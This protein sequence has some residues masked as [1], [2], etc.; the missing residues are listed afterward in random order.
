M[1]AATEAPAPRVQRR[2][3]P[4]VRR[5]QIVV[6]AAR[7]VSAAGFNAVSLNDIAEA[8]EIRKSSVLHHFPSM[9]DL[10]AAVLAYRDEMAA[11][12]QPPLEELADPA[13]ASAFF[14]GTVEHNAQ[15]RELVRLYAVLRVE[16]I[17]PSHPAHAYFRNR[18]QST[19]DSFTAILAWKPAP[20][21]AAREIYAF[22]TGLETLWVAD[23]SVDMLAV[24][25]S[26][27]SRFFSVPSGPSA[28]A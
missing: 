5:R 13:A 22:W 11:P 26:F 28:C 16:A 15:H 21:L 17:D 7:L 9:V 24:W 12:V 27:A 3:A 19:I 25:D 14:R 10:L 23:P 4:E 8:C 18:E 6:E 2:L 1:Q 20:I